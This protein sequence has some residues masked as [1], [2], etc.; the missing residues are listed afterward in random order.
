MKVLA[1][2]FVLVLAVGA[3]VPV[4]D[5]WSTTTFAEA[6]SELAAT[7]VGTKAC[8]HTNPRRSA[9]DC[10]QSAEDDS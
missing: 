4:V 7:T 6:R 5:Q 9:V 8:H 2:S 10:A 3:S 1:R